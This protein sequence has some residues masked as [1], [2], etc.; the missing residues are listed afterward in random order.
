MLSTKLK[1]RFFVFTIF[2]GLALTHYAYF[3]GLVVNDIQ[4]FNFMR[5]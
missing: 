1:H 5:R 4:A 3:P 2:C